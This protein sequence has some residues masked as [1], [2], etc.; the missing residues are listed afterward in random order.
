MPE[1]RCTLFIISRT[2]LALFGR[3]GHRRDGVQFTSAPICAILERRADGVES[4]FANGLGL[5]VLARRVGNG[6]VSKRKE[7]PDVSSGKAG[8]PVPTR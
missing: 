4:A 5:H 8:Y 3:R 7:E 2:P 1:G 6:S